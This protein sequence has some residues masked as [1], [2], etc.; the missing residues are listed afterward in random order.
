MLAIFGNLQGND[1]IIHKFVAN[2]V[3]TKNLKNSTHL[4]KY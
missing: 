3:E 4:L 2:P 1:T